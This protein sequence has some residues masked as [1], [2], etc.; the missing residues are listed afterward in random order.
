MV[1]LILTLF[2]APALCHYHLKLFLLSLELKS[3][4]VQCTVLE[5]ELIHREVSLISSIVP[6]CTRLD[7][8]A[9]KH[10]SN[11]PILVKVKMEG[12]D[13]VQLDQD[14]L[15]L[16]PLLDV[17]TLQF[18]VKTVAYA[19]TVLQYGKLPSLN[20]FLAVV[21]VLPRTYAGQFFLRTFLEVECN[22][23]SGGYST[24]VR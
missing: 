14:N 1:C 20:G 10:L 12:Q 3:I 11:L 17:T 2:L 21:K 16:A 5:N 22:H 7:S 4:G 18:F 6:S 23:P 8:A 24:A 19:I 15:N 9:W 13:S